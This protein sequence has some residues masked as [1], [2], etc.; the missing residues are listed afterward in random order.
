[1]GYEAR[2]PD[3]DV[4][5]HFMRD[6]S[7]EIAARGAARVQL[8]ALCMGGVIFV[9]LLGAWVYLVVRRD[10]SSRELLPIITT[11]VGFVVGRAN[12]QFSR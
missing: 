8:A 2:A 4:V 9:A 7:K 3:I 12:G 1:M 6:L 10:P 5:P 11:A